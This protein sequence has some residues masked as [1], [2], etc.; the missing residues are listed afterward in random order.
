MH[1]N[2]EDAAKIIAQIQAPNS[3]IIDPTQLEEAKNCLRFADS[4]DYAGTSIVDSRH[5]AL[6][7]R[8]LEQLENLVVQQG[9]ES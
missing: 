4:T 6:V 1:T 9:L 8:R 3:E 7:L 2:S 5:V